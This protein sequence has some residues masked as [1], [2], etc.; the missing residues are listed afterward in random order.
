MGTVERVGTVMSKDLAAPPTRSGVP[1]SR[2]RNAVVAGTLTTIVGFVVV[3]SVG[4]GMERLDVAV[5]M[6]LG[7]GL[8]LVLPIWV[9]YLVAQ[10]RTGRVREVRVGW[11]ELATWATVTT[12]L[13]V[14]VP[15][16]LFWPHWRI[17]PSAVIVMLPVGIH[18]VAV[19]ACWVGGRNRALRSR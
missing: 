5:M 15:W 3:L 17:F 16:A 2:V 6:G 4:Y 13:W 11:L 1:V 8:M 10:V 19:F 12:V 18:V 9:A 7:I 14:I